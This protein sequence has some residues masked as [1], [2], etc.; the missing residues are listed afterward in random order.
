VAPAVELLVPDEPDVSLMDK[1]SS[2]E[3]VAGSFRGHACSSQFS[4]LIVHEW[5]QLGSSLA[6]SLLG[7]F[8]YTGYIGHEPSVTSGVKAG[9]EKAVVGAISSVTGLLL[10]KYII[11]LNPSPHQPPLL[12][13][14]LYLTVA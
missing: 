7:S 13:T 5:K 4:Q 11:S 9:N 12:P 8:E 6:V 1:T 3:G 2:V 14:S 10:P